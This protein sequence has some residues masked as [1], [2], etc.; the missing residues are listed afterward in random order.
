VTAN[1]RTAS[2]DDEADGRGDVPHDES[3]ALES[4]ENGEAVAIPSI[5]GFLRGLGLAL[6]QV[7]P[8]TREARRLARDTARIMRGTDDHLP[9]PKD[10]RFSDP[11]WS[12]NPVY[13]RGGQI[14]LASGS[15]ASR[16][17]D[18]LEA[19]DV[20][21]HD[22][23]RA[24]FAVNALTSALAPTN[25][26][27]GNPAALKRAFDTAGSSVVRGLR[28]LAHDVRHNGGMPSQTDRTAFSVGEDLALT[29][30]AVV[31]RS[32]VAELIQYAPSTATVRRRPVL[33]IPPPIGRY[34]FLD[35]RPGRSFVEYAVSQGLQV[36]MLSWR[37]PQPEQ[38]D[39][40]MDDYGGGVV[41]A[42][43]TV[44][45]IT[46]ADDVNTIGF[47]AGGILMSTVLSHL[48]LTGSP[49]VHSASYG[50][51]LLDFDSEAPIGAFSAPRLLEL[52]RQDSRRKG[53]ISARSM[54]TV[55]A[56]MRPDD[57]VFN[58]VVNQWLMGEDPPVFDILAW[59]ADGTN[60]PAR[61][62]EQFLGIFRDN[63]LIRAGGVTVLGTPVEL[64]RIAVPTFVTGAVN[65]HLTPWKGCYR[66]TQLLSGPSTFVLSNA[67][68]VASLVNPPGN[69]KATY[70]AG[71]EPGT[72]PETW[73]AGAQKHT[74]SWWEAW[75]AWVLERSG[76]EKPAP[77]DLGSAAHPPLEPAPGSYVLDRDPPRPAGKRPA[78]AHAGGGG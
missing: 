1:V 42:L 75:A 69:P 27:I 21:W 71:G 39:W 10:K 59:N 22:V 73:Q 24:R 26:A 47:C 5:G 36:F 18:D 35:L 58:Y 23:E 65:D 46:G 16:L 40:G 61:L 67:G 29:P 32:E 45:E 56:W 3:A 60:L 52:A 62:H 31:H 63:T 19:Q 78:V 33:V 77:A 38:A 2:P 57:L 37:N 14:Y 53:I 9:S 66:T 17:V 55:F 72:D 34:Y 49:V 74:G 76:E 44:R 6:A 7:G 68:H 11:A 64:S 15:A 13:R 50:V 28:N 54:G 41:A 70:W 20:D 48:A 30:G 12:Q 8:V 4:V 51:T 25:N 43:D